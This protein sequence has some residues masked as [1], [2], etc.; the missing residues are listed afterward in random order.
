MAM[1]GCLALLL[2]RHAIAGSSGADGELLYNGIRLPAQWPPR[3]IDGDSRAPLP[4]PYLEHPPEVIP[5]DVGR[6]LFVDDFLIENTTL[7]RQFHTARKYEHNP[8]LQATTP[9]EMDGGKCPGAFVFHD[10]VCFDPKEHLF[11]LW[12]RAGWYG[13]VALATSSDGLNWSRPT[14][15]VVPGTNLVLP[16]DPAMKR[17]GSGV[18]LDQLTTDPQQRFKMFLY[19]NPPTGPG[20]QVY[21]SP[22]G[23]HWSSPTRTTSVGD[24]TSILYNPFRRKWVYSDRTYHDPHNSRVRSYR[25]CDDLVQGATWD[26]KRDLFLWG[27]VDE[28]DLPDP[29]IKNPPQ[30]YNLDAT[31]YESLMLGVFNVLLGPYNDVCRKGKFPKTTELELGYSRDGF[32]FS[33]PDRTPFIACTQKEGDWDR[34]YLHPA[35]TICA[36]VGDQ[37]YFYF[38][39]FSGKSPTLGGDMYAGGATGV[40]FLRRDGFASM[41]AGDDPGTL[42]TR[43]IT[44]QGKYLFVNLD[45]PEGELRVE[46]L[47]AKGEVIAPFT[48]STCNPVSGDKTR[49]Q[50]SWNGAP[51]LA[52]LRGQPVRLRFHLTRGKLYAFWVTPDASGASHGYV[53]AGGPEFNGPWDGPG[54]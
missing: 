37:L 13:G 18:W 28:L 38:T 17:N 47:D 11:K 1:I 3:D 22:D 27:R 40:A 50:I 16:R 44:F 35:A 8:I 51:D 43:P 39:A 34:G 5:I 42:T 20:G 54:Q 48:V 52:P 12:Y 30:L 36:I 53:A 14:L 29:N 26:K 2:S 6:Q 19:Q 49:L 7:H 41:E 33:R 21:T 24:N 9:D 45:A 15:D 10:G 46:A 32:H 25:E 4:V 31:G 23:I